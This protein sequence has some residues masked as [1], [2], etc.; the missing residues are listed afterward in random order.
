MTQRAA[1][2]TVL[3]NFTVLRI[4]CTF[5]V[6]TYSFT[7]KLILLFSW[8]QDRF[9]FY[10]IPARKTSLQGVVR[11]TEQNHDDFRAES[12]LHQEAQHKDYNYGSCTSEEL[13]IHLSVFMYFDRSEYLLLFQRK[14]RKFWVTNVFKQSLS[15]QY[16]RSG[17]RS[18]PVDKLIN[19]NIG[20]LCEHLPVRT[21]G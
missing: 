21:L 3:Y 20:K 17:S 13:F 1:V 12:E 18:C 16:R 19:A 10:T 5:V 9:I 2:E 15:L 14:L 6:T 8:G 4:N 11:I 7:V